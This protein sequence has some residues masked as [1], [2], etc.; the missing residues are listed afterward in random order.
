[1]VGD[2]L[3][4]VLIF[5]MNQQQAWIPKPEDFCGIASTKLSS[6]AA[7]LS[8]PPTG[9]NKLQSE[10]KGRVWDESMINGSI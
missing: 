6:L 7:L 10:F 9:E 4:A 3:L 8:S 2:L 5:R 1:M